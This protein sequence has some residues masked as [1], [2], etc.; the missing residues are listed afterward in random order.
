MTTIQQ[1]INSNSTVI[2]AKGDKELLLEIQTKLK[3]L[4]YYTSSLDGIYGQQTAR[5]WA[6][7]KEDNNQ[8]NASTVGAGSLGLLLVAKHS[9]INSKYQGY[10]NLYNQ[11]KVHSNRL[12]EIHQALDIYAIN[13]AIYNEVANKTGVPAWVIFCIHY[14]E[15]SNSFS[16]H[17]HN[18]DS[19]QHRTY[20]VPAGRPVSSNPPFTWVESAIDALV[21]DGLTR[22]TDWSIPSAL[23]Q[24]EKF[25]GTG[26]QPKGINSPYIWAGTTEYTEGKYI[27]DGHYSS[28]A[29][30]QQLG[31]A[32]LIKQLQDEKSI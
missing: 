9:A 24:L 16:C 29:V 8:L 10:E 20:H 17:L 7:F 11:A 27:A 30:D 32:A 5:G 1:V 2:L 28:S 14:R 4:G 13:K 23:Y 19:L 22:N 26:Y 31:C 3:L 18:G 21:Y 25:N 6:N 15:A 12:V